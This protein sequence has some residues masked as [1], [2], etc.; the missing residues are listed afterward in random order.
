MLSHPWRN[1]RI[2][3]SI[4]NHCL[5]RKIGFKIIHIIIII[6]YVCIKSKLRFYIILLRHKHQINRCEIWFSCPVCSWSL[7]SFASRLGSFFP[8][9]V[10]RRTHCAGMWWCQSDEKTVGWCAAKG[11]GAFKKALLYMHCFEQQNVIIHQA[12]PQMSAV[13][14]CFSDM[15]SFSRFF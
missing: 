10:S 6:H 12:T 3:T 9:N 2:F 5:L 4:F 1:L 7:C 13:R 11:V 14:V 8:S 15:D